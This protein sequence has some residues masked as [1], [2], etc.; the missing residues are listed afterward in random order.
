MF[1]PHR[2]TR[3]AL[4]CC[5]AVLAG[6]AKKDAAVDTTSAVASSTTTT[7]TPP[8][9]APINLADVA[10][11]WDVHSVPTSGDTTPTN[12][13]LTALA[14]PTGW[15]MAYP[16]RK[17]PVPL[18]VTADADSL[19]VSAGPYSSVRRKGVQVTTNGSFHLQNGNL[20]GVT[21]AHYA[22]KTADSVL[23]LNATGTRAK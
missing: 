22:V 8:A 9:P 4:C 11:K 6:C 14:T 3:I 23:T 19:I 7:T 5:A 18:N 16:G 12:Y 17:A 13:V 1:T 10:G 21:T 2:T 20:V 15:S